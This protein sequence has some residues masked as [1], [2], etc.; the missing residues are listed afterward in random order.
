MPIRLLTIVFALTLACSPGAERGPTRDG[1]PVTIPTTDGGPGVDG[2]PS[3]PADFGPGPSG[4]G[5]APGMDV[6][7][8]GYVNG[9]D[10]NDCSPQINPGAYDEPGNGSDE[11]CSGADETAVTEC[12]ASLA[13]SGSAED[14]ARAMGL[15]RFVGASDPGWGVVSARFT[16]ADGTGSP[17]SPLMTGVLPSLGAA[18]PTQGNALLA[19]SSGVARSPSQTGWTSDCDTFGI[20]P[21]VEVPLEEADERRVHQLL[22]SFAEVRHAAD[23]PATHRLRAPEPRRRV[24][25][26]AGQGGHGEDREER[27]DDEGQEGQ[28]HR[29]EVRAREVRERVPQSVEGR[30]RSSAEASDHGHP[31]G[32][33]D[34]PTVA[35]GSEVLEEIARQA[36]VPVELEHV[37][38]EHAGVGQCDEPAALD[39]PGEQQPIPAL[40]VEGQ[41]RRELR[42]PQR[43]GVVGD[44]GGHPLR[45]GVATHRGGDGQGGVAADGPG[46]VGGEP[47][48]DAEGREEP[49]ALAEIVRQNHPA[50]GPEEGREA[51]DRELAIGV[52]Q[53]NCVRGG[54]F[55]HIE[56][57]GCV[58]ADLG[59]TGLLNELRETVP[60]GGSR[61]EVPLGGGFSGRA[62]AREP[63]ER[64]PDGSPSGG[65]ESPARFLRQ[66]SVHRRLDSSTSCS[67]GGGCYSTPN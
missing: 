46:R 31:G 40:V 19:L 1:G 44:G 11:D 59:V 20:E 37:V 67:A 53:D 61:V 39:G 38:D 24:G 66:N 41:Q 57:L 65:S 13:I 48:G 16:R 47:P 10:C 18:A 42:V 60:G 9:E 51:G 5:S 49:F 27:D 7:E 25:R 45:Q 4:C 8:D 64:G 28:R 55:A 22:R 3:T 43:A 14:A 17:M 54:Q 58:E 32:H 12:D 50:S 34:D 15:C 23:E 56:T 33:Q 62:Q 6:D 30:S 21:D 63:H 26:A 29:R 52:N 35:F 36:P 2:G